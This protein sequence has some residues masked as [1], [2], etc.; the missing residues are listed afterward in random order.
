MEFTCR[1]KLA[2]PGFHVIGAFLFTLHE[3]WKVS[4]TDQTIFS[5]KRKLGLNENSHLA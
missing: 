1:S 3:P 2:M 4:Q 5:T